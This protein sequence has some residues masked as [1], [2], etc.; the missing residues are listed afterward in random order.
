MADRLQPLTLKTLS[1]ITRTFSDNNTYIEC[2][3]VTESGQSVYLQIQAEQFFT[4]STKNK[5]ESVIIDSIRDIVDVTTINIYDNYVAMTSPITND[6]SQIYDKSLTTYDDQLTTFFVA[7]SVVPYGYIQLNNYLIIEE[8]VSKADINLFIPSYADITTPSDVVEFAPVYNRAFWDHEVFAAKYPNTSTQRPFPQWER[9]SDE[10]FMTS[11]VIRQGDLPQQTNYKEFG[12]LLTLKTPQFEIPSGITIEE[13]D[14]ECNL[15]DRMWN[16]LMTNYIYRNYSYNGLNFDLKFTFDRMTVCQT[17]LPP[18]GLDFDPATWASFTYKGK[19]GREQSIIPIAIGLESIDMLLYFQKYYPYLPNHKLE[20]VGQFI[21]GEGKTGLPIEDLF[22]A[23]ESGDAEQIGLA[24]DYA[25]QDSVLLS[26]LEQSLQLDR[27]LNALANV[28]RMT[29]DDLLTS[30]EEEVIKQ[31]IFVINP[32]WSNN[33][34][35]INI[36]DKNSMTN[37][38]IYQDVYVYDYSMAYLAIMLSSDNP[39][40]KAF[41]MKLIDDSNNVIAW[42]R[43]IAKSFYS[44]VYPVAERPYAIKQLKETVFNRI[45][46]L[47]GA[48]SIISTDWTTIKSALPI[49]L[50]NINLVM[51]HKYYINLGKSSYFYGQSL[52]SLKCTG[53]SGLCRP[54]FPLA[55][56]F[57]KTGLS[58]IYN[59][60]TLPQVPSVASLATE[61]WEQFILLE[62]FNKEGVYRSNLKLELYS[63]LRREAG[64]E[65]NITVKAQWVKTLTG[66]KLSGQFDPETDQIDYPYY[67][68]KIMVI[69]RNMAKLED[70]RNINPAL[71]IATTDVGQNSGSSQ[72][73]SQSSSGSLASLL[74]TGR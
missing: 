43:L 11:I 23:Y 35:T 30:T 13:P 60:D 56:S 1:W 39:K 57:I 16:I 59:N 58:N 53:Q 62:K 69:R 46:E 61:D 64:Q 45:K 74:S 29:V 25:I 65:I 2:T 42:P 32:K 73:I 68:K 20:T 5:Y 70:K 19:F 31:I 34:T 28:S 15:I 12:Y 26:K 67:R 4:I 54:A 37:D 14:N 72:G 40:V 8:Q 21:L 41:A 22:T 47:N 27:Q 48:N 24:A 63:Q 51:K 38:G 66:P 44:Q 33:V 71:A 49:E 36:P 9:P 10:I 7:T 18:L 52:Q 6:L 55:A 3:A 50:D 17:E